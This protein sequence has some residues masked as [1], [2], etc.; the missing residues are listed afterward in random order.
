[1]FKNKSIKIRL[2][3]VIVGITV[4]ASIS[5]IVSV[6]VTKG[7]E[8]QYQ[9]ALEAYGFAQG[10]V[11]K[12]IACLGMVNT[13][14][15]DHIS[16]LNEDGQNSAEE[17]Y[18][19]EVGKMDQYF[20]N[21]KKSIQAKETM[22]TCENAMKLWDQY[23][24]LAEELME[25]G[26]S[27]NATVVESVQLRMQNELTPL[28]DSIYD[29]LST[30]MDDKVE[31]GNALDQQIGVKVTR[32]LVFVI[33]LVSVSVLL[34]LTLGTAI[35]N[36]ISNPIRACAARLKLLSEGNLK[37]PVPHAEGGDKSEV[38]I[39]SKATETIV[40]G[41]KTIVED[42][43]YLLGEMAEGNFDIHSNA[44]EFYI[45]DFEPVLE[46]VRNIHQKLSDSLSSIHQSTEQVSSGAEQVSIASQSLAQGAT[47][48]AAS[49]QELASTI[50][51]IS[52]QIDNNAK[53]AKMASDKAQDVGG[54][55]EKSNQ[56][57][58]DMTQ[59][60]HEINSS[61]NEIAKIIK[62]IEDI[63]FQTNIL[64]LNA[65]V[66]AARAGAA[67]KGFAV[68]ADEVRNLASKSAEAS[69]N[70]ASLIEHSVRAVENG[71]MLT[72]ET[73]AVLESVV[74]GARVVVGVLD[75]IAAESDKQSEA[76]EQVVQNVEQ[77]SNVVQNNSATAEES[78]A[79]SEEL[80]SQAQIMRELVDEFKLANV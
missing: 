65:A 63:A 53:N 5:G 25:E 10:D 61:S 23:I 35:A 80:S 34:S 77:I 19:R 67:G 73:A 1:M 30:I 12:V 60:M 55:I 40:N 33:V 76:V 59:A 50:E 14:V 7:M 54:D 51:Q 27:V 62:T 47:E 17:V 26:H 79:A 32:N 11:G 20:E 74:E 69:K 78:A 4:L 21:V 43:T 22:E 18:D 39:L 38:V 8:K 2:L 58:Q 28:Y 64:A 57:M 9:F 44:E 68:V 24:A 41:L 3:L 31:T 45:G 66:E 70:T 52:K 36:G 46:S 72:D 16:Y 13:S 48:Q 56:K 29:S 49:V 15:H 71:A 6:F 42:E 75:S 37:E